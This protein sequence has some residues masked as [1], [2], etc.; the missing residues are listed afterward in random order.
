MDGPHLVK[1]AISSGHKPAYLLMDE[2]RLPQYR[3]LMA[4]NNGLSW[5]VLDSRLMR[6]ISTAENPQGVI[7]VMPIPRYALTEV[8]KP[9]GL[10][11]ILD[12]LGDPGNVGTIIRTAWAFAVDALLMTVGSVDPF[13]PKAVQGAMGGT[14]HVPVVEDV[15]VQQLQEMK[16]LGY[17]FYGTSPSGPVSVY[18]ADY[19]GSLAVVIGSEAHGLGPEMASFCDLMVRIPGKAGV[20]SLNAAVACGIILSHSWQCRF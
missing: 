3:D 11:V 12:K 18:T 9:E 14:L 15:T 5:Y 8:I 7:A 16:D 17:R 20:D 13:N 6:H 4:D 19:G 2:G 10:V 1:E